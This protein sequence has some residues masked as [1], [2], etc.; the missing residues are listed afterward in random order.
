MNALILCMT[1]LGSPAADG[2]GVTKQ[3]PVVEIENA[4]TRNRELTK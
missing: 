3:G 2:T 1:R 4:P